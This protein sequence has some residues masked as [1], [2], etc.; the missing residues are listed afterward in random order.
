VEQLD[1]MSKCVSSLE[2]MKDRILTA[3]GID[4]QASGPA[5]QG[6]MTS[7]MIEFVQQAST[8]NRHVSGMVAQCRDLCGI[9]LPKLLPGGTPELRVDGVEMVKACDAVVSCLKQSS[10]GVAET[11]Q[12]DSEEVRDSVT[13]T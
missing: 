13:Q 6:H 12:D 5:N 11:H 9:E 4:S 3:V 2:C 1:T 10:W 8:C 7:A